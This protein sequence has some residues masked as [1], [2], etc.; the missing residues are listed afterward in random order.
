[1]TGMV[2]MTSVGLMMRFNGY[3]PGTSTRRGREP[4][5]EI[6]NICILSAYAQRNVTGGL[7]VPL[8]HWQ[9]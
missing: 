2:S 7:T 6:C 8:A 5:E 1:M 3:S 4:Q 9:T